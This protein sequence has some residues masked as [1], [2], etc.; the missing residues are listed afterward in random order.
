MADVT[1]NLNPIMP[2]PGGQFLYAA[3]K[4]CQDTFNQ[5]VTLY[6]ESLLPEVPLALN[7]NLNPILALDGG[8]YIATAFN[9][10]SDFFDDLAAG[11]LDN[12]D[13]LT[14]QLRAI[15]TLDAGSYQYKAFQ[16]LESSINDFVSTL[17]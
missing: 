16:V 6:N 9:D 4:S 2:A 14:L 15:P 10:F 5:Y 3:F 1:L 17:P 8:E 7:L 12:T 11:E 13:V